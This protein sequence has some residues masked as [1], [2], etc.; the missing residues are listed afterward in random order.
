MHYLILEQNTP[1]RENLQQSLEQSNELECF[2][3]DSW[4]E[5]LQLMSQHEFDLALI[6]VE[7]LDQTLLSGMR[8]IQPDLRVALLVPQANMDYVDPKYGLIQGVLVRRHLTNDLGG[9]LD[10]TMRTEVLHTNGAG[11]TSNSERDARQNQ[12]QKIFQVIQ[13]DEHIESMFVADED[14]VLVHQGALNERQISSLAVLHR[15]KWRRNGPNSFLRYYQLPG[16]SHD[17]LVYATRLEDDLMVGTAALPQ[18]AI[19]VLRHEIESVVPAVQT[20]LGEEMPALSELTPQITPQPNTSPNKQNNFA[21]VWRP[22]AKIPRGLQRSLY[23][24]LEN[25]ST[26][27]ACILRFVDVTSDWIHIVVT[28]PPGKSAIWIAH[29]FKDG[30]EKQIRNQFGVDA[31]L[32]AKGYYGIESAEPLSEAELNLF[33]Q[34]SN[35]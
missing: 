25:V 4:Q 27:N 13:L 31:T 6:A 20:V 21:L 8:Q 23:E 29:Q 32:W 28:T 17:L 1:F 15:R 18:S 12:L 22:I 10:K 24:A 35:N 26:E 33:L 16:I 2:I 19:N 3:T 7:L 5:A 9:L 11:I 34:R 30:T 14:G